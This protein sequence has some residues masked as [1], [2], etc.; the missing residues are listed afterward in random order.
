LPS[1]IILEG[2]KLSNNNEKDRK[3]IKL[4]ECTV[5]DPLKALELNVISLELVMNNIHGLMKNS[6][7][8]I[9]DRC[10]FIASLHAVLG[11]LIITKTY[12]RDICKELL[13]G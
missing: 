1:T 13:E 7:L 3:G 4:D 10:K 5:F 11:S 8:F 2:Y 9:P 12:L 6:Q